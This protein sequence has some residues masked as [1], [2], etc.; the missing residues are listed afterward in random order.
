MLN[1]FEGR[2]SN[3]F[4]EGLNNKLK[5]IKRRAYGYHN[6]ENFRLRVLVECGP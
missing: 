5:L 1:Y 3:G 4:A 2:W 6:F